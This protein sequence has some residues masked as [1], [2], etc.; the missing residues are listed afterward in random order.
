MGN[1]YLCDG[2]DNISFTCN[3]CGGTYCSD[4]RLP[5][6]HDCDMLYP[7]NRIAPSSRLREAGNFVFGVV[8]L[9]FA[10]L[11]WLFVGCYRHRNTA[12]LLVLVAA[13]GAAAVM[14]VPGGSSPDATPTD[15]QVAGVNGGG[16]TDNET[17]NTTGSLDADRIEALVHDR[18]NE[19]RRNHSKE[20]LKY[21][22][23]IAT[24]AERYSAQMGTQDFF[25][26]RSPTG[27]T[28]VDR[29]KSAGFNCRVYIG[30]DRYKAGGENLMK[31]YAFANVETG[32]GD[33]VYYDTNREVARGVVRGWMN[34]TSHRENLL[35]QYWNEEGIGVYL[36]PHSDKTT[37]I[38]TQ[39]FC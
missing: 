38:V 8:L 36:E 26:H 37:V 35:Y 31:M 30:G 27:R 5:E 19:V 6:A 24:I 2:N 12:L 20:V 16:S 13:V 15:E 39:N 7:I 33:V 28:F 1:C 9:P 23:V 21:D 18:I 3:G 14:G 34:S 11:Y 25:A 4:H 32:D 29:Y 22:P 10:L 17:E